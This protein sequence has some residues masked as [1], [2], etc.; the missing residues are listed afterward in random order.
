MLRS[1]PLGKVGAP[2]GRWCSRF[3]R[4]AKDCACARVT[5]EIFLWP[6]GAPLTKHG[7]IPRQLR[8]LLEGV[9]DA[10]FVTDPAGAV[11]YMN[12]AAIE[13][14][15]FEEHD[16]AGSESLNL[17]DHVLD[18]YEMCT[19]EGDLVAREDQPLVRALRGEAYKDVE[20][21]VKRGGEEHPRVYVFSGKRIEGTPPLG[22]LTVRDET[23]RWR[24]ERRYRIAFETDPAPSVIARLADLLILQANQGMSDLTGLERN[25]LTDRLLT[26]LEPLHQNRDLRD[27]IEPL[28]AGGSVHKLERLLLHAGEREMNV[29]MSARAIEIEG[30]ASGIFTFIDTSELEEAQARIERLNDE[31]RERLERIESLHMIERAITSSLDLDLTL[32][33]ILQ[34]V[35]ARLGVDAASVLLYRPRIQR[36]RLGAVTG[37][38]NTALRT[39]DLRLGEGSAGQAAMR[40]EQVRI[41]DPDE[42]VDAFGRSEQIMAEGVRS[43]LA[44]PLVAKGNLHGVLELFRRTAFDVN[45]D[46]HG[47]LK[48]LSTQVAIALDNATLFKNSQRTNTE[49]RLAYD[50]TI[51]GWARALDLRDAVTE[52]HSRRVTEMTERLAE[53]L[54]VEDEHLEH[55]RRGALLHDIGKMAVPDSI[56]RKPDKLTSDEWEIMMRHPTIAFELLVPITFLRPALDIPYGHHERWDGTGYPRKLA[57][58][59]IPLAARIF[60]VVDVY[61]ALTSDRP[62]REAW[63][64]EGALAHIE[65]QAGRQFDPDVVQAFLHMHHASNSGEQS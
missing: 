34:Q 31:L 27:T 16:G 42:F 14:F 46:W 30:E 44:V 2:E 35:T 25:A 58:E 1:V 52:G 39:T 13:L 50:T 29:L 37:F 12:P 51:E 48:T 47:F 23:D 5:R 20:L 10:L 57:G 3:C 59:Q 61:D 36:L 21:L 17:Q 26:D 56:L 43:Y 33:L 18:D 40:R 65:E 41:D 9:Q 11:V 54:G 38:S 62:Y 6:D 53:H 7:L 64:R 55:V 63:S 22:V 4:V 19:L 49:L 24:A 8:T 28:R 45:D 60:S 15:A 32:D